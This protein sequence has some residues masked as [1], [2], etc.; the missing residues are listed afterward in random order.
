MK[1]EEDYVNQVCY[2]VLY[3]SSVK[4]NQNLSED[5]LQELLKESDGELSNELISYL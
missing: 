1:D 3:S 2:Y 5:L 4:C